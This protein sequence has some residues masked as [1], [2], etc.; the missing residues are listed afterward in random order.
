MLPSLVRAPTT[1]SCKGKSCKA[2]KSQDRLERKGA[3]MLAS[4]N[5]PCCRVRKLV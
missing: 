2:P 3:F 4:H 5:N 1:K